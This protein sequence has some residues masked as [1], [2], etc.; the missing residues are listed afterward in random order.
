[1]SFVLVRPTAETQLKGQGF[2]TVD[3]PE[4]ITTIYGM[5]Y[6][7]LLPSVHDDDDGHYLEIL[8]YIKDPE[9][10]N[11]LEELEVVNEQWIKILSIYIMFR[12][13]GL[14]C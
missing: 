13:V 9:F 3:D 5:L 14:L 7:S 11:T 6:Q 2:T 8:A 12:H 4:L 1:M 10:P